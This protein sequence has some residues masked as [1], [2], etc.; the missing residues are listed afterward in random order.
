MGGEKRGWVWGFCYRKR[1]GF[2]DGVAHSKRLAKDK[3]ILY[4]AMN[5]FQLILN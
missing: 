3:Q 5:N 1:G 4:L 2:R